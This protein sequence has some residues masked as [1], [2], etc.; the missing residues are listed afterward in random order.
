MASK[1][2]EGTTGTGIKSGGYGREICASC[3][4]FV[5]PNTNGQLRKHKAIR[6]T[7]SVRIAC[8]ITFT[9]EQEATFRANN[10]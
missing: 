1:T 8:G 7:E 10:G 5:F 6:I 9:T 3:G 4:N 2:C